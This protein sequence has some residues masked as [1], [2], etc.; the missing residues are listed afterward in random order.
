MLDDREVADDSPTDVTWS[1]AVA[2]RQQRPETVA[3]RPRRLSGSVEL[4]VERCLVVD[5]AR[6]VDTT[7]SWR[8][9]HAPAFQRRRIATDSIRV[10]LHRCRQKNGW[11]SPSVFCCGCVY[12]WQNVVQSREAMLKEVQKNTAIKRKARKTNQVIPNTGND[13]QRV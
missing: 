5:W 8:H 9:P 1:L 2:R 13:R 12:L 7:R 11:L 4:A 10:D 6:H 3:G